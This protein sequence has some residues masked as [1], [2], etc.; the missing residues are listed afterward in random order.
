MTVLGLTGGIGMGKSTA[1]HLLADMGASVLDTD[2]IAR[3]IV[4]PGQPALAEIQNDFGSELI[5]PDGHLLRAA[6]ADRVFTDVAARKRLEAILHP[7]IREVWTARVK[8]LRAQGARFGVVVIPLLFETRAAGQFDATICVA[9][10]RATQWA[11]LHDRGWT[12]EQITQRVQAQWSIEKKMALAD[13]ITWA[14]G[15]LPIHAA[16]LGL[17]LERVARP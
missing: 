12:G 7:R 17:I 3:E 16:Q 14:E 1:A 10:S 4:E 2:V 11:R 13:F 15:S 5:G 8:L 9:C 6:L